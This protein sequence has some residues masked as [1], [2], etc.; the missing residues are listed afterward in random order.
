MRH[1]CATG[2]VMPELPSFL[3]PISGTL[4][5]ALTVL[6]GGT[7]G[8]LIGDR[9]PERM[10]DSLFGALGLF[11]ILIGLSNA[12]AT[13][14]PLI[15]LGAL[16]IGTVIGEAL[17]IDAGLRALGDFFQRRLKGMGSTVSEAFVTSSLVFCVGPLTILGSLDNGLVGDPTKLVIKSTLDG[18]AALAFG[19]TLGWGVLLSI[20]TI[21]LFQGAISLAAGTLAPVLGSGSEALIELTATGGLILIA[22]GLRLLKIRELRTANFLPA[23]VVA[24]LL[25]GAVA[26]WQMYANGTLVWP[27]H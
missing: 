8:A 7:I 27:F 11:T 9:L 13:K 10:H 5:N 4:L 22:I 21:L 26:L 12:L 17:N 25:V 19:A 1:T 2:G 14:N 15:L 16:L 20:F 6:I 18:F 24:P 23:L 3:M